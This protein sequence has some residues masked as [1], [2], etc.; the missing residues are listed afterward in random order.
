M[1]KR[2]CK[3]AAS[4]T[5]ALLILSS[6]AGTALAATSGAIS[7]TVKA[8]SDGKLSLYYVAEPDM[9]NGDRFYQ[10]TGD[11]ADCTLP[12][13]DLSDTEL[14]GKLVKYAKKPVAE[15]VVPKNGFVKFSGL[16]EGLYLV[17][18][19]KPANGYTI[20]PF[21]VTI[22]FDGKYDVNAN[23]KA[24][25]PAPTEPPETTKPTTPG[26]GG[27]KPPLIQTG[28][29]NW[30]VPVLAI[31]GMLLFAAGWVLVSTGKERHEP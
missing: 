25:E 23:A 6:V 20:N 27:G 2:L 26:G 29:L 9:E 17:V 21:L 18:Q 15:K 1:L 30:P 12:L 11:F 24:G 8:I 7:V 14:A 19:H 16:E 28:Q 13:G 3:L 22:P 10:Y 5:F 4:L 31:A